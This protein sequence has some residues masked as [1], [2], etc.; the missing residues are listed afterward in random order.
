MAPP[1]SETDPEHGP[2][3]HPG[4]ELAWVEAGAQTYRFGGETIH[5][6][7]GAAL[8]IPAG[9]E[10]SSDRCPEA[11]PR[12]LFLDP[13]LVSSKARSLR[14]APLGPTLFED[15]ALALRLARTVRDELSARQ[16]GWRDAAEALREALVVALLRRS[17]ARPERA[18][19][20]RI[21]AALDRIFADYAEALTVEDLARTASMSRYHFSR[22]FREQVGEAPYRFL[23]RVRL[24]RAAEHLRAGRSVTEAAFEVGYSGLGRFAKA[25]HDRFGVL[26]SQYS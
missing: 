1:D 2:A 18:T 19:D 24:E 25:F 4:V 15:A 23:V 26:P 6:V 3:S 16:P 14:R 11:V 17:P 21:A 10:H 7:P 8:L 12:C 22:V 20:P 9:V 13:E 5:L